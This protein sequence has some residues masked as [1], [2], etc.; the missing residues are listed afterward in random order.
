MDS[1][2]QSNVNFK[3]DLQF[4]TGAIGS[5]IKMIYYKSI[6]N[7]AIHYSGSWYKPE[8]GDIV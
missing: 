3:K 2:M 8:I 5:I 6:R 1:T 4:R 7:F